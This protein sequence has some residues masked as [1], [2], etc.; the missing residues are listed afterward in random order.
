MTQLRDAAN[1][2]ERCQ[3]T[4]T[5]QDKATHLYEVSRAPETTWP[6]LC[7]ALQNGAL[8]TVDD[9]GKAVVRV[10][11]RLPPSAL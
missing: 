3:L 9:V 6:Q 11:V 5:F 1:V 2:F 4:D 10:G 7:E 8:T